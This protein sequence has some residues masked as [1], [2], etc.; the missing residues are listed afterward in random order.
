LI[1]RYLVCDG[2]N[3]KKL[4]LLARVKVFE[5]KFSNFMYDCDGYFAEFS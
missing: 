5:V 2:R 3:K 4:R 1:K